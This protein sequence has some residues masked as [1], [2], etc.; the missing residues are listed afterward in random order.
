MGDFVLVPL[1]EICRLLGFGITLNPARTSASGLFIDRKRTFSL[2]LDTGIVEVAGRRVP[3]PKVARMPRDIYVDARSLQAWFPLE[4]ELLP[5]DSAL[6]LTAKEKLPIQEIWERDRKYGLASMPRYQGE[7]TGTIGVPRDAPYAFMD[8]PMADLNLAANRVAGSGGFSGAGSLA[9]GGDLLWMSSDLLASRD[10]QGSWQSSR[11][12]LFRED[13][14]AGLLGPMKARRLEM[15]DL[16]S[17][18]ALDLVGSLP[19][20]RGFNVDNFP[21][22]Y[23]TRF[24]ARTFRGGLVEGWVVELFQNDSLIGY[25]RSRPDGLYEF[26]DVPLQFGVNQFRLVFHGPLG[27]RQEKNYRLDIAQS[28]PLAGDALLRRFRRETQGSVERCAQS[29]RRTRRCSG[30]YPKLPDPAIWRRLITV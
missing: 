18:N 27:Q 15:G 11:A 30:H 5:K 29:G 3:L 21:V 19:Q 10:S 8:L 24:T 9:L 4:V 7:G 14:G 16:L 28:Q 13:A 22:T 2:D 26:R 17:S 12:T 23:R 25:Q 1:G 20:G 6:V